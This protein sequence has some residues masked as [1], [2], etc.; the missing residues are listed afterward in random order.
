MKRHKF[1]YYSRNKKLIFYFS[2]ILAVSMFILLFTLY[3]QYHIY[4]ITKNEN[5]EWYGSWQGVVVDV[6]SANEDI[7][8]EHELMDKTGTTGIYGNVQNSDQ[9]IGL[10][11]YGDHD[12]FD[13]ANLNLIKGHWPKKENEII[14][15]SQVLD[16][17]RKSYDLQQEIS[18]TVQT[19]E[20][21]V[22]KDYILC[23]IIDNYSSTWAIQR[24]FPN[25][26][27]AQSLGLIEQSKN[28]YLIPQKGYENILNEI[29]LEKNQEILENTAIEVSYNPFSTSNLSYTVIGLFAIVSSILLISYTFF[30]WTRKHYKEIQILKSLGADHRILIKDLLY[31]YSKSMILP[32]FIF[33]ISCLWM[34]LPWQM[35]LFAVIL[36]LI[37]L[38][39]SILLSMIQIFRIPE[40]INTYTEA[41]LIR[42]R[43]LSVKQYKK[44]SPFRMAIR[45]IRW[46]LKRKI[47]QMLLT[48]SL[49]VSL[50]LTLTSFN[51]SRF[52]EN[53]Y[54]GFSDFLIQ[55]EYDSQG[56]IKTIDPSIVTKLSSIQ[57]VNYF[58]SLYLSSGKFSVAWNDQ[59][60]AVFNKDFIDYPI[61]QIGDKGINQVFPNVL[62]VSSSRFKDK[63]F[64]DIDEGSFNEDTFNSGEEV[65]LYLPAFCYNEAKNEL[66]AS[67]IYPLDNKED[68]TKNVCTAIYEENSIEVGDEVTVQSRDGK[69]R[70]AKVQGIIREPLNDSFKY[71]YTDSLL[72]QAF[73]LPY[74]VIASDNF[75]GLEDPVSHI[76]IWLDSDMNKAP[77]EETISTICSNEGLQLINKSTEKRIEVEKYERRVLI[78]AII[79]A[80]LTFVFV[81]FLYYF[82]KQDD[83]VRAQRNEILSQLGIQ[84]RKIRA[85]ENIELVI[86]LFCILS[87]S[88]LLY[89]I[90]FFGSHYQMNSV[91]PWMDS[92]FNSI[93]RLSYPLLILAF[94]GI[95][96]LLAKIGRK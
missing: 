16:Q 81:V 15:E 85:I 6:S 38:V 52:M 66:D 30:Q 48:S 56:N 36:F 96:V 63:I 11:G 95:Y 28:I 35:Y 79:T 34:K 75:F 37:S 44:M 88:A 68:S 23:G 12:F 77:I 55:A 46:N 92:S 32:L 31:L 78:Y 59:S 74:T 90:L 94:V 51:E 4:E 58:E 50:L 18:V 80:L 3:S 53:Y 40:N 61:F 60:Q 21:H 91:V 41:I 64:T 65:I 17:L 82:F 45:N 57:G 29:H 71:D 24:D 8:Q 69:K 54:N 22:T 76:S 62:Y 19:T 84:R 25:A 39:L 43:R 72:L 33:P 42:T 49:L 7:L 5:E 2:T 26:F 13:M 83:V 9:S 47:V 67:Q 14:V 93:S 20:G 1:H 73:T 27:I 89:V 86:H 10:V 87:V 70:Q